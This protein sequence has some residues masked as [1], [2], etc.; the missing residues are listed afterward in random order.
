MAAKK[1]ELTV[2]TNTSGPLTKKL[3]LDANGKL[4]KDTSACLMVSGR[5]ERT[6]V[7]G[8]AAFAALIENLAP[9]QALALGSMRA[10]LPD[11]VE[12]ITTK[13]QLNGVVQPN[14]IART[15]GNIVYD[16]PAFTL[17][18]YD[19]TAMRADV[20]AKL[21]RAGGFWPALVSVLPALDGAARVVR[22]STS[23]GLSRADTGAALPGSDGIH[24]FIEEK[25]GSDS[26]RFLK[27]LHERCWLAGFGWIM[28]S[29]SGAAL[30]RSIIDRMVGGPERLVFEGGPVLVPPL[31]QDKASRRPVAIEGVALD[32]V[33]VCP[34]LSLIEQA[35]LKEMM[36]KEYARLAPEL[37]KAREAFITAKAKEYV[38]RTGV[39][40]KVARQVIARQCK[41][42]LWPGVVLPFDNPALAG[43]TVGDVLADPERFEG[44]TLADPLEGVDYGRCVAKIMRHADGT[45]WVHSFAHGRTIYTLK[46]DAAAVRKAMEAAAKEDVVKVYAEGVVNADLDAF[47]QA[48]LRQLAKKLS[49]IGLKAIDKAVEAAQQEQASARRKAKLDQQKACRH[50]PR[51]FIMAPFPDEPWLP[52]MD[53]LN[54]VI[55]AVVADMPPV[56]DADDDAAQIRKRRL[57]DTHAF[58]SA[59]PQTAGLPPPEQWA[60]CKMSEMEVAEMIEKHI[61]FY[62]E[63]K[64]GTCRSVHLSGHFVEHYVRRDDDALPTVFA[65]STA[66]LVLADGVLLAPDGLD[67]ERGIQFI[68]PPELRAVVPRPEDCTPEKVK[69][70]MESLCEKWLVDVATVGTGKALVIAAALTLIERSLMAERPCFFI[71]AG[72]R[73]TGKTTLIIMLILAVIG[74]L[75]AA[76]AW[77]SNEEERRKAIMAKLIMGPAYILWDNIPRGLQISCPHLERACT[78]AFYA[79]R[80]LGV[81]E[82]STA[83]A[84]TIHLFTGNNI[85]AKGD[86]ASRSLHIRL[87][88]DRPDPE[89]RPFKHPNPIDWTRSHRAEILAAFYTILLGNPQLKEPRD[90]EGKTRFK[91]W[92]RLVGS[93]VEHAV[94]QLGETLDF[95]SLFASQEEQDEESASLADVLEILITKWP[96]GVVAKDVAT[97]ISLGLDDDAKTLREFLAQGTLPN[98]TVSPISIG[99]SLKKHLDEPVKAG[100]RTLVLRF[101]V[102]KHANI[103]TYRVEELVVT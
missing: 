34:P 63:N 92:W 67:C 40:E 30:E 60:I 54:E 3:S 6:K 19:T 53:I 21:T 69:A 20:E 98:S 44:E 94:K 101:S 88:T 17:L 102:D 87:S 65:I 68:I 24:V 96:N 18:D 97:L 11:R 75:P 25:D 27:A 4:V 83:A 77:A 8:V 61:D 29:S 26:V 86:L 23:S 90:A 58:S 81:S 22:N 80:R 45:P 55:G 78:S 38:A 10:D 7:A 62:K 1:I 36:E 57:P 28:V 14:I 73:G 71:S 33:A 85:G 100:G 37:A 47:E 49:G 2:L 52:V 50:D 79:D 76:S 89:N 31:V 35:R 16:G 91:M 5:A 66:P 95:Q 39:S 32:T 46:L 15:G 13:A 48:E 59:A 99:C 70:A 42:V 103:K 74:I 43:K 93:A 51:P 9:T 41:G 72:R 56:R 84:S 82:I 64:D 12:V